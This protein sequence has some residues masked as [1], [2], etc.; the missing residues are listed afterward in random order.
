MDSED[1]ES[2]QVG[3]VVNQSRSSRISFRF[4]IP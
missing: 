1:E 3:D 4:G 2:K